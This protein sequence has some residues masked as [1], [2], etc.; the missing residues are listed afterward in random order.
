MP[1]LNVRTDLFRLPDDK[2]FILTHAVVP[3]V[4]LLAFTLLAQF[5]LFDLWVGDIF[6]DVQSKHWLFAE[7]WWANKF[8]HTGGRNLIALVFLSAVIVWLLSWTRRWHSIAKY[9][10][11]ALYIALVILI[12]TSLV[13]LG[14]QLTNVDCPWSL[15][16]YSGDLPYVHLFSDK[17][18]NLPRGD[19]FPGG[20]SSAGFSMFAWYFVL[21][22][23]HRRLARLAF[24]GAALLGSAYALVQW[25]RGAHF[26]SHDIW[27]ATIAWY[28]ALAGYGLLRRRRQAG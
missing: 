11:S 5:S 21:R 4:F 10:Y 13:G 28:V 7:S 22:D 14:K 18:D 6:F 17:P 8:I 15:E 27:S 3:A 12:S 24:F 2:G 20:H 19:C 1:I 9:R 25:G 16:R 26:P 23:R